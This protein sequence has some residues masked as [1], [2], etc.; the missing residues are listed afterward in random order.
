MAYW[1]STVTVAKHVRCRPSEFGAHP[2]KVEIERGTRTF[3]GKA[4]LR[5]RA[6]VAHD[7]Y[8]RLVHAPCAHEDHKGTASRSALAPLPKTIEEPLSL[9][10][11][12]DKLAKAAQDDDGISEFCRFYLERREQ[13][14]KSA[15]ADER[16]RKQLE[17]DFSPRLQVSIVGLEGEVHRDV[18][19]AIRYSI[20]GQGAYETTLTV[21]PH[22]R[23]IINAPE[24]RI[25]S[26]S[27]Q[28]LPAP[29]LGQCAITG[30]EVLRHL[31]A[32]SDISGRYALPERTARCSLTGKRILEDEAEISSVTGKTVAKILLKTSALSGRRAEPEYFTVCEFTG[33]EVLKDESAVS[34]ISGKRYRVDQQTRSATSGRTGHQREFVTCYETRERIAVSEAEQCEVTGKQVRQG[35][36]Q[37]C[38]IS[39]KKV[40]PSELERCGV[41][42]K[43]ALRQFL[44]SSSVSEVRLLE[45]SAVRSSKGIFC[46][47]AEAQLCF[48]SGQK[49]HPDDMRT[50][51]LTGLPIYFEFATSN[52]SP[53]LRP[54]VEMLDGIRRTADDIARWDSAAHSVGAL[55]NANR[56]KVEA[57][58]LSPAKKHLA[59]CCEFKTLLGLRINQLGAIYDL[60]EN[61]V[62][63]RVVV[64]RRGDS[65][66][67]ERQA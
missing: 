36:L 39:G 28:R 30:A 64:G 56:C 33:D 25:C 19:V 18:N 53:R 67:V 44:V 8:E 11:D 12:P 7:S 27:G 32:T 29:C 57:A 3:G 46:A 42:G 52:G 61:A 13:E 65:G 50:C 17:D 31:L 14:L 63:G 9:G 21:T 34:E 48:W 40:L 4:L 51:A 2:Q 41:T 23:R 58:A 37:T 60:A 1:Q 22:D 59:M 26:K 38:D 49:Y 16:K 62:A 35:V 24:M 54:L 45:D 10:L 55:K 15:G 6:T 20:S 5:V 43:R 47:P 66:W